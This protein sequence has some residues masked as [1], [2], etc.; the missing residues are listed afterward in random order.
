[1]TGNCFLFLTSVCQLTGERV[2][3]LWLFFFI[4][5]KKYTRING[6]WAYIWPFSF[7]QL[8]TTHFRLVINILPFFPLHKIMPR[9]F[10]TSSHTKQEIQKNLENVRANL[11]SRSL[12]SKTKKQLMLLLQRQNLEEEELKLR[13]YRELERFQYILDEGEFLLLFF[14]LY[15][16]LTFEMLYRRQTTII[17][18]ECNISIFIIGSNNSNIND[19]SVGV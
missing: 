9:H 18:V 19:I 14:C 8:K 16:E 15:F 7:S 10:T 13:H 3:L 4:I 17:P 2:T 1:M 11:T 5:L 6:D 12:E